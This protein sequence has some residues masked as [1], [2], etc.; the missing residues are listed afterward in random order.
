MTKKEAD[1][2]AFKTPTLRDVAKSAPYMHD[3]S[4]KT[5]EEVV[6]HYNK[7][8]NAN[9]W[10][11]EEIFELGLEEQEIKDLVNFMKE[12]LSSKSYPNHKAPVLP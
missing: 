2:G 4:Q 12:G 9:K 3:G 6:R 5:L 11:D 1:K 8:G 7:G 10:L